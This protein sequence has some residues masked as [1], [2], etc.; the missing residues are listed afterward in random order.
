MADPVLDGAAT[1]A[2]LH[3]VYAAAGPYLDSLAERPVFDPGAMTLLDELRGDL[4]EEGEGA[5]TVVERLL[6]VGMAAATGSAG[7]GGRDGDRPA[8]R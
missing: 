5:A 2:V 3:Q 4:P 7:P 8:P 6:R 1:A